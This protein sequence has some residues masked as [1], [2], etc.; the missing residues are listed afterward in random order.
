MSEPIINPSVLE[1]LYSPYEMPKS[2]RVRAKKADEP[3]EIVKGRRNSDITIAQ[4]LRRYVNQWRESDYAGASDT[5]RQLLHYWFDTDHAVN[6]HAD[7]SVPFRYY[8]CQREAI[9]TLIYLKEVRGLNSLSQITAEFGGDNREVAALGINPEEDKWAKYA[10]KVA[11]GA[12]K[13]KIMS[14]A[15]VW[16]YFHA[17][18]EPHSQMASHFVIIAPNLTVFER[19]KEDFGGGKIFDTDPLIPAEWR[20]DWNMSVTLQDDAT[21]AVTGGSIYLT[22]IHRLYDTSKRQKKKE[23][24]TY[25][26]MGPAVYRAKALDIG[27][28]LRQ[29]LTSHKKV[30]ILNDEAHHVWDPD[31]A[32]NEAI[33][34]LND[35]IRKKGGEGL[36]AQLDFSA[37]P[38]D[39][40]GNIFK[41][42]VCD[43]PLGEAVDAGIVKT[44]IIGKSENLIEQTSD[45]AS[46]K[47]QQHLLMGYM[48]WQMSKEEWD[49]SG[50]K[51]I[52]F[53]MTE[54]TEAANQIANKF[55]TDP[56]YRELNGKTVNLHTNLKG[57]LKKVGKG[58]DAHYAFIEN[59]NDISDEDLRELRKLSREL[60]SN[61]SPYLCIVSVLMLREGWDVRN[62]TTIVPL[63]P[64]SSKANILP[65]QTLG[66][67]L[68]RMTPAG[69]AAELVTVVEHKAFVSL[70]KEQLSQEGLEIEAVD[71]DKIPKTTVSIY[72]DK[73]KDLKRLDILIPSLS[74]GFKRS[75]KLED[76]T[77]DEVK[78]SFERFKPLPL[79]KGEKREIDYEGRHLFTNEIVEKMKVLLPLLE[80][81]VGAISFYREELERQT[82]LKGAHQTLAP[83]IQKFLEEI[84]FEKKVSI[85]DERLV[86]RLPD[87]DV[88]E[89]IRATFA[90]LL[91]SKTTTVE[92]RLKEIEPS[93]VCNWKPYQVTHTENRPAKPAERTPFNLVP[94]NREFEA[95]MTTF[96]DR[97]PDVES[98]CKNAGPQSL[99]IDYL[100]DAGRIAFYT[101]DF[102]VK[103]KNNN[104]VLVETKGRV[105]KDVPLKATAAVSWC[106]S[107]SS[108]KI[109]WEYLY[110]PQ[111]L[112][113]SFRSNKIDELART[114]VPSLK[115]LL[116]EKVRP[117]IELPFGEPDEKRIKESD[118]F[119]QSKALE[120]L[121]SRYKKSIEQAITLYKFLSN[122]EG[123][124][125]SAVFTPLLGPI[126]EAAKGL[127]NALL[128]PEMPKTQAEQNDFFEPYYGNLNEKDENYH[129]K[130]ATNLKRTLLYQNGLWPMGLLSFCL[131][132]SA[133][134]KYNVEGAFKAIKNKFSR[135][136][137]TDLYDTVRSINDFRNEYIAHQEKEL[138]DK[139]LTKKGLIKWITGLFKIYLSHKNKYCI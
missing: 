99:R 106:K 128:L 30:M 96:L 33:N 40:K 88:R 11:T 97:A 118:E 36:T 130:H 111:D 122:K 21:G 62:V 95:A 10:F 102:I 66:R 121:P 51:A 8:F 44:P 2:H 103:Q 107:A 114:C 100:S 129:K 91:L 86:S 125:F 49:K 37:T 5:T 1:P 58:K 22:N 94:C 53:V 12:G 39:N 92:E 105:D 112:F 85:F 78:K 45:D 14:L 72:P 19:L 34:Y 54:D 101:P 74:G 28:A 18:Q 69:Q 87:P 80:S 64:Y 73:N 71:V 108:K 81:G 15:I 137:G 52:L 127:I 24:E 115:E 77:I 110:V 65:E 98:F 46:I 134:T 3:A 47:Y 6:T 42:V 7:E 27:E 82:S 109:K 35:T 55:N 132:Y 117:Q 48:R 32:W 9:E 116:E 133:D 93:S 60:D 23:E 120:K 79:G 17:L 124:S 43:A 31:S 38:K 113:E 136:K 119:I 138:T 90:P 25:T 75:S 131:D 67:G 123:M 50:K 135:F 126:D 89:H 63:R 139:E 26:W 4:N 70:Y 20:S 83:L 13:T 29:R 41:H 16:S 61:Q 57:R 104:Y 84:L 59:E 56:I 76:L 68:R